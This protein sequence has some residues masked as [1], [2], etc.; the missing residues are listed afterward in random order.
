MSETI[1]RGLIPKI[2]SEGCPGCNLPGENLSCGK[3]AGAD[4]GKVNLR[5]ADLSG[6]DLTSANL[7]GADLTN[8]YLSETNLE[9]ANLTNP[10]L[11]RAKLG[12]N[13][14]FRSPAKM[15]KVIL[16]NTTMPNLEINNSGCPK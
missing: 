6:T 1:N 16:C 4:L 13:F 2:K 12:C 14:R 3:L 9:G 10:N 7:K 5:G 11:A 15:A 8:A